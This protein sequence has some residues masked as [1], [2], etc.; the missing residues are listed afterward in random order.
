MVA[1]LSGD[2]KTEPVFWDAYAMLTLSARAMTCATSI[3][4]KYNAPLPLFPVPL[5]ISNAENKK[6]I[7]SPISV[8]PSLMKIAHSGASI[9]ILF[10][11]INNLFNTTSLF[12]TTVITD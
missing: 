2:V 7:N 9:S 12:T 6:T 10:T 5:K 1:E 3:Y 4:K 8:Y 11:S